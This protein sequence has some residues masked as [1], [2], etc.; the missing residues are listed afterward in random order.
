MRDFWIAG[1]GDLGFP[2]FGQLSGRVQL[3][4][5]LVLDSFL[6]ELKV[7]ILT[8]VIDE[9]LNYISFIFLFEFMKQIF[10]FLLSFSVFTAVAQDNQ[11]KKPQ[12]DKNKEI[13]T[14]EASCG[15]CKFK[16]KGDG[17]DLAVRIDGK[18]YFVDGTVIDE[19]GD[20]HAEDGFCNAIRKAEVQ[21]TVVNNRFVSTYFKLL[22]EEPK[23]N[24]KS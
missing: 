6:T 18:S 7:L 2:K 14:V 20:A 23:K 3:W 13:M 24:K 19:H 8:K 12:P 15:Q 22:P 17:C 21:G 11:D 5:L 1:F 16:M 10:L 9:K 4:T